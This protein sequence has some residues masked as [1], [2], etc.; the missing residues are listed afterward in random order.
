MTYGTM[1]KIETITVTTLGGQAAIEFINIKQ[2]YDD[3]ILKI[4][5]REASTN[6]Y[7]LGLEING[8][9]SAI[10]NWRFI[11]G[12]GSSA[13]SDNR[14]SQTLGQGGVL[15][16]SNSTASTFGSIEIYIPNYRQNTQKIYSVDSVGEN[17]GTLAYSRLLAGL[18]ASTSAITS[19]SLKLSSGNLAQ[20]STATLY[21][22]TRVPAEAKATGGLIADDAT[23]W[24]HIFTAS[25]TFDP[26][27][28][29]SC[30]VLVIAGGGGGASL[31]GGGGA[32]GVL[33]FSNQSVSTATT[34]TIGAGASGGSLGNNGSNGSTSQFGSL[35]ATVGGAGGICGSPGSTG[36]SGGG[37][38]DYRSANNSGTAGTAGQGF[39]GGNG[40]PSANGTGQGAGGGGGGGS[41]GVG[42]NGTSNTGGAGGPGTN[43]YT[44]WGSFS[45][46]T[47]VASI[48]VNGFLAGGGGGGNG[49]TSLGGSGGVGG[50]GG[51]GTGATSPND[52]ATAG[53]S[54]TG[55]GGGG[56]GNYTVG[57]SGGSGLIVIR[58]AK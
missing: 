23:Y 30:D 42:G 36:G 25:G 57:K 18:F 46:L 13:I 51:G 14:A 39:A 38:G 2:T 33:A 43:T 53:I 50:S 31:G 3:L 54:N 17:N 8:S 28:S 52:N 5:T 49:Q 32:G 58:Y 55:S 12:S 48:G 34:V 19:L 10:Y 37:G 11:Q 22:I 20:H 29:L 27:Q 9:S 44:N 24:Y 6:S 16:S 35:T 47:S 1:E 4:S 15:S 26:R 41:G 21:G 56:G 7:E 40:W 45:A